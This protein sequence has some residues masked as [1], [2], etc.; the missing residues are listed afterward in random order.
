MLTLLNIFP[1]VFR[2]VP[3]SHVKVIQFIQN[4]CN[5]TEIGNLLMQKNKIKLEKLHND[6]RILVLKSPLTWK[7][8][9]KLTLVITVKG[10]SMIR[11]DSVS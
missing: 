5:K 8:K 7:M 4:D 2:H 3:R 10:V 11:I 6:G 9:K 1:G